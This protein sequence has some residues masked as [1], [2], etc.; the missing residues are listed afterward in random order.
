MPESHITSKDHNGHQYDNAI[1]VLGAGAWGSALAVQLAEN[2]YNTYL[3]GHRQVHIQTLQQARCNARYLSGIDFPDAL[4]LDDDLACIAACCRDILLVVPSHA[5]RDT[6]NALS[7]YLKTYHRIAWA[8]KGIECGSSKLLHQVVEEV[9][10]ENRLPMAVISGPNFALEVARG[11]PSAVTVASLDNTFAK[12][13]ANA[14]HSHHFRIYTHSDVIGVEIGGALKNVLAIAAGISDSLGFGANSR[15]ALITRGLAELM[16]LGEA[17]GGRRET[18]MGL[19]GLGDLI[20]T[21]TDDQSRNRRLGLALGKGESQDEASK[22]IDQVVEGIN[23]AREVHQLA[24][25]HNVEMPICEQVYRVL[26]QS[27]DP[28]AA[29]QALLERQLRAES[30]EPKSLS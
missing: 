26:Y 22:A 9:L 23:T 4:M 3:W 16:R 20:L 1:A 30:D 7:P 2:G 29:V 27:L 15:A 6:L 19:S 28:R 10:G 11:L 21:C 13:L 5:F 24:K 14:L 8:T 25:Q 17:V 12:E 18:F